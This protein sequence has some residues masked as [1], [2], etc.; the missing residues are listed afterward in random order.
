VEVLDGEVVTVLPDGATEPTGPLPA[1]QWP[2]DVDA[3][4]AMLVCGSYSGLPNAAPGVGGYCTSKD[5]MTCAPPSYSYLPEPCAM[6]CPADDYVV[7]ASQAPAGCTNP[8]PVLAT[9][10]GMG[11]G[12]YPP[13]YY[14]CPCE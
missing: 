1:C 14:C 13:S 10:I 9:A 6:G 4:R 11:D 3:N 12:P 5:G 7:S 8:Y 2:S